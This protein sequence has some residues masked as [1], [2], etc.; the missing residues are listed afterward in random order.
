VGA[1]TQFSD[2]NSAALNV[3]STTLS[4]PAYPLL[5]VEGRPCQMKTY[6]D[7]VSPLNSLDFPCL[8]MDGGFELLTRLGLPNTLVGAFTSMGDFSTVLDAYSTGRVTNIDMDAILDT[9]DVVIHSLLSLPLDLEFSMMRSLA[10]Y[11]IS[12]E[13]PAGTDTCLHLYKACRWA[14]LLYGILVVFPIPHSKWAREHAVSRLQGQLSFLPIQSGDQAFLRL[15]AWLLIMGGSS[16]YK[17]EQ[18]DWFLLRLTQILRTLKIET[19][20][21]AQKLL[22]RFAWVPNICNSAALSFWSGA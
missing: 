1:P 4:L 12:P 13:I 2:F 8:N 16:S 20:H 6:K 21:E 22:M 18:R 5:D 3:A 9:R 17:K 14:A 10:V 15:E 11:P 19:W 7:L